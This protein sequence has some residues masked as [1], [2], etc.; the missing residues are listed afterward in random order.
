MERLDVQ[1]MSRERMH[2][3]ADGERPSVEGRVHGDG[4]PQGV[5]LFNHMS[6][7]RKVQVERFFA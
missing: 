6:V 1:S 5:C 4:G 7:Q 2:V 3:L